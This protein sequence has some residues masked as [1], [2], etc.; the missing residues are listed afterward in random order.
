MEETRTR[1]A[2]GERHSPGGAV[3]L[4]PRLSSP[5]APSRPRQAWRARRNGP[6]R[7]GPASPQLGAAWS[8]QLSW[9]TWSETRGTS[10]SDRTDGP[11]LAK[12]LRRIPVPSGKRNYR[13][14]KAPWRGLLTN[15]SARREAWSVGTQPRWRFWEL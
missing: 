4:A 5:P 15:G 10:P 11:D 7:S 1:S 6:T 2:E 14:Q 13:D 12:P 8:P 3:P 9:R